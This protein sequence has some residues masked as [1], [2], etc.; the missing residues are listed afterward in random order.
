[1]KK[2]IGKV[3]LWI[4]AATVAGLAT[5][6]N[7]A[8]ASEPFPMRAEKILSP[9][10]NA[11]S[12]ES[13]EAISINPA[14]LGF[15]PGSELRWTGVRCT[16]TAKVGCG[17]S[18]NA[19]VSLPF[20]IGT[21][22]RLDYVIPPDSADY[23][24]YPINGSTYAWL[25]WA[26]GIKFGERM[27]FGMSLQRSYSGNGFIDGMFGITAGLT[28][29][30]N[31]H[32]SF[33]AIAHDFNGPG[34]S[35]VTPIGTP[36]YDRSYVAAM[37]LR[38]TGRRA[39]EIG[40]ELKYLEATD[41]VLPKATVGL[42]IPKLGRAR[43]DVEVARLPNDA[44]RGVV[45]TAGLELA[46]GPVTAGGGALFGTGLGN[47]SST[48]QYGVASIG[49]YVTPGLPKFSRTVSIRLEKTPGTR[50]HVALLRKLWKIADSDDVRGV[51]LV[52]RTEPA[53]SFAHAEEIADAIRVI[54]SRGKKVLC[55][56]EDNGGKSL[57][58]CANAD[59]TV[60]NSAGGLRFAGLKSQYFYLAGLLDKL[61]VKAE[62]VRVSAHKSAPEQFMNERASEVAR[63]DHVDF[64]R[65]M[66]AV[67]VRDVAVGRKMTDE[68]VR[69][70]I[71][72]GPFVASEARDAGFVDGYAFDDELDRTMSELVGSKTHLE[73]YE[74]ETP[75]N[76]TF[77]PRSKIGLLYID[78][79]I[80]DGRS[81]TIPLL[82]MKLVGSY[83]IA[84]EAKRL[85]EDRSIKSV[86][87]RIESPGGSSMASD[88]MWRELVKLA[89]KK[90][91][92]V[93][94]GST[95]ASGGYYVAVPGKTVFALPLTLTGSIG[96]FYGKA[97]LSGLLGKVGVNVETYKTS[98]RADAESLFRG[99]TEDERRELEHKVGQFYDTF[100]D[101]VTKG[102]HMT[103]E[104]VDAVAQGRVW[105]GQQ[106][107]AHKLVDRLGGMREALEE[108]RRLSGLPYDAPVEEHPPVVK[109]LLDRAL[110]LGGFD[111]AM[112]ATPLA[113]LPPQVREVVRSVAPLAVY[114]S[115]V[116]LTR[117]ELVPSED[118]ASDDE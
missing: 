11:A 51:A 92:V 95:A 3:S 49:S 113:T 105:T 36:I 116:P 75:A 31:T 102:R 19:A 98:P 111:R 69:E 97:D 94:M 58:V 35:G 34:A 83:T 56:W 12:E 101:R 7:E 76:E 110:E 45:A 84:E 30:P 68:R 22:L 93:S 88:V 80:I 5:H 86:V 67:F 65:N 27:A 38:P 24:R 4:L 52:L 82:G 6:A 33:A 50:G 91:L 79:D 104:A 32:F 57:Y 78:G 23:P 61:G 59:R 89:E 114:K 41:Q 28:Y 118:D 25:T 20:D 1:M 85:R 53:S 42:D 46:W 47:A 43:A 115:D 96:V 16:D 62:F 29:R 55:S 37:A 71:A 44:R 107:Y 14:N 26:L 15:S 21:G 18:F 81:T 90:P 73:K 87:L 99:F 17:H 13:S 106:A 2:A 109:T 48:G 100:L 77:G 72:K 63:A 70:A 40:L 9:G 66:E 117:L 54:R 112:L 10:R 64:L 8:A 60:V 103:R 74:D 39:F 108:A